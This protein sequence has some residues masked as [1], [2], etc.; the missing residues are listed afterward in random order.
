M[1]KFSSYLPRISRKI[2]LRRVLILPF[3]L[4]LSI[5]VGLTGYL[6][7]R[8]GQK[9]VNDL[10]RQLRNETTARI[11]Q[12]LEAYLETPHIVNQIN[13]NG[14]STGL[15]D[16]EDFITLEHHFWYQIRFFKSVSYIQ[17]GN[18]Q[19]KFIGIERSESGNFNVE[20]RDPEVTGEDLY[21]YYNLNV[22]R[23]H[24][25]AN[26]DITRR[27]DARKRPWY[28]DA[29]EA[30]KPIWTD[31][32]QL[33]NRRQVRLG[34]MAAQPVYDNRGNFLGVFG[35]DIVLSQLSD[36]LG[37]LTI[38]KSGQTFI[39]ERDG[40]LVASSTKEKP[41]LVEN[42]QVERI[43][44]TE[45]N[46]LLI[47]STAQALGTKFGDL[48]TINESQQFEFELDSERQ[49]AQ[50]LPFR[51]DRGIDWLIVAVVPEA[52]F[53]GQINANSR[54]TINLCLAALGIATLVGILTSRWITQPIMRL[55]QA[56]EAMANGQLQQRVEVKGIDELETLAD[57][58]NQMA[59]QVQESFAKLETRVEE[60]TAKLLEAKE[61]ADAA[62]Q[63]K[64]KFLSHMSH[65]LR[66]PLNT[67]LGFTRIMN[68]DS[69]L[70]PEQRSN[71]AIVSQSGEHL[72]SLINEILT[73]SK[74]EAGRITLNENSFDLWHL[75]DSLQDM[76]LLKA[77]SKG[78]HFLFV[79]TTDVPR[80]VKADEGKLRQVFLNLLGNAIKF[81]KQ[82]KIV[83]KATP[84][85][86]NPHNVNFEIEDTGSGI[87]PEE[88]DTIFETFKQTESGRNSQQGSGLGL[89]ISKKFVQLLGGEISVTSTLGKGTTFR[90]NIPMQ[91][92][93]AELLA[94]TSQQEV[95]ALAPGQP[96]YRILVVDDVKVGRMLLMKLLS[97]IGFEVQEAS[98][99]K[100][101]LE[102]WHNW[103]PHLVWLDMRMP[104][105]DGYETT[106]EI[107]ASPQ[108]QKTIIIALTA[109]AFEE[110][111]AAVLSVGCDDFVR[112]PFPEEEIFEKMAKHL[113]V[114]YLYEGQQVF[115]AT[116]ADR[117]GEQEQIKALASMPA[118]WLEQLK[119]ASGRV[120]NKQ[121]FQLLKQIPQQQVHLV[122]ALTDLVNNFRCDKIIDLAKQ[123]D[124]YHRHGDLQR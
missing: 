30:E 82:G 26:D 35:A 107:K 104:I 109:S 23:W 71:L 94:Q 31:I 38:G 77:Q 120:D 37:G 27:Y 14:I 106:K 41:A 36:F 24:N 93:K 74:I 53:M 79:R 84:S 67:I 39:M 118:T 76:L 28:L 61:T 102:I 91:P 116:G 72:L 5:A 48:T 62:N 51:D 59:I 112:K 18:T 42:K 8:H 92:A 73:M 47:S 88:L 85:P 9:A 56:S 43:K 45:S 110:E 83:L 70:K 15:L 123:A 11:Q 57:S 60:R 111:R 122:S 19:G 17:F 58:F 63:A 124:E 95:V 97:S 22:Q 25:V 2:P 78:L 54:T 29:Q 99:G 7:L 100:E 90:F 4:Q 52:D 12:K 108:G 75:L 113:G 115:S 80:Y 119:Q 44:A 98:N 40:L 13:A 16:I 66:T 1:D 87:A 34:I 89:A 3:V 64:T 117:L 103:Q 96:N 86:E 65:E 121:I 101:A 6:S 46:D 50:V 32:Y 81:T 10:A 20:I 114:S 69:S 49:F 105:M 21:T 55:S 68:R 33:S